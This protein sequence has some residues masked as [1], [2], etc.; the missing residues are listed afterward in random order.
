M[1]STD[2]RAPPRSLTPVKRTRDGMEKIS[3]ALPSAVEH[4]NSNAPLIRPPQSLTYELAN[5]AKAYLKAKQCIHSK[6]AL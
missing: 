5:H 6:F 1:A 2:L 4:T 3:T